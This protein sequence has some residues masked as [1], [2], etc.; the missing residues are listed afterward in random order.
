MELADD[1]VFVSRMLIHQEGGL[2]L[3]MSIIECE[4]TSSVRVTRYRDSVVLGQGKSEVSVSR[5]M[6]TQ[7]ITELLRD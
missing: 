6:L 4:S 7:L 5:I 2:G 1:E 3:P